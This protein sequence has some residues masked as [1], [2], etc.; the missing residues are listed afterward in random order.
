MS[1]AY[2]HA[3]SLVSD[4]MNILMKAARWLASGARDLIEARRRRIAEDKEFYRRLG[5]YC[6]ANHLSP[7]CEDDWKTG[8]YTQEP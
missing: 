7:V 6:R 3:M 1:L 8:A 4:T 2:G 5:A